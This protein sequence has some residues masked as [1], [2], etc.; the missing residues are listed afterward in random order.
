[1]SEDQLMDLIRKTV[2][3]WAMEEHLANQDDEANLTLHDRYQENAITFIQNVREQIAADLDR[4]QEL[5]T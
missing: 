2:L 4:L 3:E 5:P 1:M